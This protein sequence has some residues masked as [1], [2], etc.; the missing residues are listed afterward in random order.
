MVHDRQQVA[1][2]FTVATSSRRIRRSPPNRLRP[3]DRSSATLP[4]MPP[5]ASQE[6]RISPDT[7]V[8]D[9]CVASHATVSSKV[10]VKMNA[11]A[12]TEPAPRAHHGAGSN[13]GRLSFDEG[14]AEA[15]V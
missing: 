14:E 6:I 5:T 9:L 3:R 12:P 2:A 4:M 1:L 15:Q 8:F 13:S 7:T 11:G 10:R